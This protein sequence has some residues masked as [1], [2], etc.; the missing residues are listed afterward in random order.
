MSENTAKSADNDLKLRTDRMVITTI[1]KGTKVKIIQTD[2]QNIIDNI[3]S[4]RV[5][6]GGTDCG[7]KP[8]AQDMTGW[9][10]GGYLEQVRKTT[11]STPADS[12]DTHMVSFVRLITKREEGEKLNWK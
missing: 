1:K 5:Q 12:R 2:R 11:A 3:Y 6:N 7:G 9:Y 10:F 8:L 4:Y